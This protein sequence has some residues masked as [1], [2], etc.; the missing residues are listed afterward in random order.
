[1]SKPDSAEAKMGIV[2]YLHEM[3]RSDPRYLAQAGPRKKIALAV[4]QLILH[5]NLTEREFVHAMDGIPITPE[6]LYNLT[7]HHVRNQIRSLYNE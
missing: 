1:M 4:R 2:N 5:H 6:I 7:I 3:A